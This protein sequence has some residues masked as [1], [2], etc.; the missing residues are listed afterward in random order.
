MG[1][2]VSTRAGVGGGPGRWTVTSYQTDGAG[3]QERRHQQPE[4]DSQ[5]WTAR[6]SNGPSVGVY[7]WT[8]GL[9]SNSENESLFWDRTQVKHT[10]RTNPGMAHGEG[11]RACTAGRCSSLVP[12]DLLGGLRCGVASSRLHV[13]QGAETAL[14]CLHCNMVERVLAEQALLVPWG[15]VWLDSHVRQVPFQKLKT[16]PSLSCQ[17]DVDKNARK[18]CARVKAP[19]YLLPLA[20]PFSSPG[21][22]IQRLCVPQAHL[23][24]MDTVH[25]AAS[26]I[27]WSPQACALQTSKDCP[28]KGPWFREV[29][30]DGW[31]F[32][33]KPPTCRALA[34]WQ[35]C[36]DAAA[37]GAEHHD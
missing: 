27:L 16:R 1:S 30:I 13:L 5:C 8:T 35:R 34:R 22:N 19:P 25:V 6:P 21:R 37:C 28:R 15:S 29:L 17:C 12:S 33:W 32:A 18:S 24:P 4:S 20:L 36:L 31:R 9:S 23:W 7:W 2:W 10:I 26:L 14:R 3:E 11:V